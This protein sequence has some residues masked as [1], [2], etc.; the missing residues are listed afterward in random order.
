MKETGP[1]DV[2]GVEVV[3]GD[4]IYTVAKPGPRH[5]R[6]NDKKQEEARRN[7]D[8]GMARIRASL[9]RLKGTSR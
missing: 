2:C 4:L 1:C 7:L 6:C 3:P 5:A 8:L 9:D